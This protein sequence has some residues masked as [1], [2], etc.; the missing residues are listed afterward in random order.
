MLSEVY[1][2]EVLSNLFTYTGYCRQT[3]TFHQ[4]VIHSSRNDYIKLMEHL[5]RD[6]LIMIGYNND[7]YDYPIIHHMINHYEE[8]KI[9]LDMN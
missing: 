2:I 5:H 9:C 8:Y 1:D 6:E 7:S 3:Q 4:F